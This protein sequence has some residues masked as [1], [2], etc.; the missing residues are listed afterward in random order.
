MLTGMRPSHSVVHDRHSLNPQLTLAAG[1]GGTPLEWLTVPGHRRLPV[2]RSTDV[3]AEYPLDPEWTVAYRLAAKNGL[4]VIAEV[5]VFP[6]E[7]GTP[8]GTWSADVLGTRAGVPGVGLN[9]RL[10]RI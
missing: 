5:R 3:W 6:R 8:P 4:P 7:S 10:L 2:V 9:T 1:G